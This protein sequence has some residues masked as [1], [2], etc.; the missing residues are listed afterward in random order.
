MMM[1]MLK[2]AVIPTVV[3]SESVMDDDHEWRVAH[4]FMQLH[5]PLPTAAAA[6]AAAVHQRSTDTNTDIGCHRPGTVVK[7]GTLLSTQAL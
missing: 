3:E 2:P 4:D 5:Q 7:Q 1:A 6:A